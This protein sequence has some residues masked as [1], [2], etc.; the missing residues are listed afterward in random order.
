VALPEHDV[1]KSERLEQLRPLMAGMR[2]GV[3]VVSGHAL[4]GIDTEE[5]LEFANANWKAFTSG[6]L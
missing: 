2:M 3:A 6:T 4:P 1:E 5:D